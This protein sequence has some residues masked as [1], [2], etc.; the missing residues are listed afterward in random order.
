M[1]W[2]R[3]CH[4]LSYF[5]TKL[6]RRTSQR[7]AAGLKFHSGLIDEQP[8]NQ[9]PLQFSPIHLW[10][11]TEANS[12]ARGTE[13]QK[14]PTPIAS[15]RRPAGAHGRRASRKVRGRGRAIAHP[16]TACLLTRIRNQRT[17]GYDSPCVRRVWAI[18]QLSG[19]AG[20][21]VIGGGGW[22]GGGRR[23]RGR[24]YLRRIRET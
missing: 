22:G 18:S 5:L 21:W 16:R 11:V 2:P 9:Q 14:W 3:L 19:A 1:P 17:E 4:H 15:G 6:S 12:L 8:S 20:R 23:W 7:H 13:P 10:P 24:G